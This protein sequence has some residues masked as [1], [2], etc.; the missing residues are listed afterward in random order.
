MLFFLLNIGWQIHQESKY[1]FIYTMFVNINP[2]Y[3]DSYLGGFFFA[4]SVTNS[5]RK[6]I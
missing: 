5:S 4:N 3:D 2:I 1:T 6:Y